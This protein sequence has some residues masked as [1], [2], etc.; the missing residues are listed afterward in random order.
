M[1]AK[2][3]LLVLPF[4]CIG[5]LSFG[6]QSCHL[7]ISGL[8]EDEHHQHP[9][10]FANVEVVGT[11]QGTTTDSLGYFQLSN[12]CP[13]TI[14]L[15]FSRIGC[16][17]QT[18]ELTLQKDTIVDFLL[19]FHEELLEEISVKSDRNLAA[20]TEVGRTLSNAM[21]DKMRGKSL[22]Q[23]LSEIPGVQTQQTGPNIYKPII[24]GLTGSRISIYNGGL[25]QEGQDWGSDHA[26]EIDLF[27]AG[28]LTVIKGAATARYGMGALGGVVLVEAP[29]IRSEVGFGG[30]IMVVGS[31]NG[32]SGGV[33]L[34]LEGRHKQLPNWGWRVQGSAREGGDFAAARYQLTNTGAQERNIS[35]QLRGKVKNWISE[36]RYSFFSTQLGI[37]RAAHIGN[38]TDL[39]TALTRDTP[40]IVRPFSYDIESPRQQ[41]QHHLF[42]TKA[43]LLASKWGTW[44]ASYG[45]QANLRKEYDIRRG[46]RSNI[47]A[48][49]MQLLTHTVE[50]ALK[51]KPFF[52]GNTGE[53]GVQTSLQ[54]NRNNEETGVS[55]LI[56]WHETQTAA[57]FWIEQL[58]LNKWHFETGLRYEYRHILAKSFDGQQRL[59]NT[60]LHFSG[61]NATLASAYQANKHLKL[62]SQLSWGFR[63]PNVSELFSQGLHHS[64]A[65]IEEGNT[66]LRQESSLKWS[67]SLEY[68][69]EDGLQIMLDAYAQQISDYIYWEPSAEPR[70][71]IRGAFPVFS[72]TQSD[73]R[74]WGLDAQAKYELLHHIILGT[75]ASIVRANNLGNGQ[76]VFNFPADRI[77]GSV[78]YLHEGFG[79]LKDFQISAEVRH[80]ARQSNT[81]TL[82][83]APPPP[84][85]TLFGAE[86]SLRI[87]VGKQ[88]LM[89][90]F[91][92][93][94]LLNT[95]Y[96]DYLNRLRYYADEV[97]RNFT[98]RI[99]C[100]F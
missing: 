41:V 57:I 95:S 30:Q 99:G 58:A 90:H 26:P 72:Y 85:Y 46:G 17:T 44:T 45:F 51:H 98:L 28:S 70:L 19:E 3:T 2:R 12:L 13:G 39:R 81:A 89:V 67:N 61:I 69:N 18:A 55:P 86:A 15:R 80:V 10:E 71:T 43:T 21:L 91:Q 68:S 65:A 75:K 78:G 31:S 32:R 56:P 36:T 49:D 7:H 34:A 14:Q 9:L 24:Q 59:Y 63:P 8:V 87:M 25:R 92:V 73:V 54:S 93:E 77:S 60:E 16:E 76:G 47:P 53:M 11:R 40:L 22:G 74:I 38:L 48:I 50:L 94:N 20:Q 66:Q 29:L 84:A 97:G 82:D 4:L 37:L 83:Y 88:Q 33:S 62:I 79:R 52:K 35:F 64:V 1:V 27:G 23:A 42:H 96:R 100:K 5:L 6:Q